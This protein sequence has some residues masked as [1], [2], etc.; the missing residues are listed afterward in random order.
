MN[1][2]EM[3]TSG[4]K[5]DVLRILSVGFINGTDQLMDLNKSSVVIGNLDKKIQKIVHFF[6]LTGN[7]F[8]F[9]TSI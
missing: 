6:V 9:F 3:N 4:L 1:G 2:K 7:F 8:G 5:L